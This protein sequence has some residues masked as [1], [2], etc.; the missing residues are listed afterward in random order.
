MEGGGKGG[1]EVAFASSLFASQKNFFLNS[2]H[3]A[4][5][6]EPPQRGTDNLSR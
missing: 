5:T 1:V 3:L 2:I 6:V 4:S